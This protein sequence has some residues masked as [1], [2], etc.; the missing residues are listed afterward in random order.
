MGPG[1]PPP[2]AN[3]RPPFVPTEHQRKTVETLAAFLVPQPTICDLL[4]DGGVSE[5]TLRKYFKDEL[6]NGRER[7]KAR[8]MSALLAAADRGNVRALTFLVDRMCADV[9]PRPV[10]VIHPD[11]PTQPIHVIIRGG[12]AATNGPVHDVPDEPESPSE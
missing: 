8:L 11:T 3:G 12:L 2:K 10:Q 7:V 5:N 6:E 1:R 4:E 9:L